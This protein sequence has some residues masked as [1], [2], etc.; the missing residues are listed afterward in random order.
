MAITGHDQAADFALP[1]TFDH[2]GHGCGGLAGAND[3]D[4]T[5]AV[6]GL[7]VDIKVVEAYDIGKPTGKNIVI[8]KI[9]QQKNY[10]IQ[11]EYTREEQEI[12]RKIISRAKEEKQKGL[13]TKIGYRKLIVDGKK[14][15]WNDTEKTLQI[16]T[17]N[18]QSKN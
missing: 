3:D 14:Y 7:G 6:G 13:K 5:G 9:E 4:A 18:R 2:F 12:Q 10:Y 11:D 16:E 15:I 1:G 8:A 17:E